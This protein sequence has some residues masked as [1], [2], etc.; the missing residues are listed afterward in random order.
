[1][2][3]DDKAR[4]NAQ[5]MPPGPVQPGERIKVIDI[6]RGF[7]LFGI[8]LVNMMFFAHP[9]YKEVLETT[10][11]SPLDR[12]ADLFISFFAEG[13]FFTLFSLLF[14]LGLAI[15]LQ[16]AEAKSINIVP[17][18]IRRL[19]V[20]LVIGLAHAFLFWFGD[21]LTYYALLGFLLLLFRSTAPRRLLRWGMVFL[22]I[23]LV[24]NAGLTG[25]MELGRTTPE[26]AA[27]IEAAFAET[28]AQYQAAYEQALTVYSGGSFAAMIPQRIADWVFATIG[29]TLGGMLFVV[30]T[31]FLVGLYIGK[32]RLLHDVQAN[33]SLWRKVFVWGA[34]LGI[35]GNLLYVMLARAGDPLEPSLM[36]L[37]GMVGYLIGAPALSLCYASGLV[38][39]AQSER[40]HARLAPLAAVGRTALSNYLLQT[41]IATTIFYGYGLG[42]YG[43]IGPALGILL[44]LLIFAVQ[45]PLSNLW[46]KRFRFGPAEWLWRTLTYGKLQPL[47]LEDER[48]VGYSG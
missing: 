17:L 37:L 4:T 23:P 24:L 46:V 35:I 32:R 2:M 27:Q 42:L 41:L 8:L 25:L 33:L 11:A 7:A 44:T 3:Q 47:R 15:Q 38:L 39:L 16:R 18:Y 1:M 28:R 26:G 45:I 30:M 5:S 48:K 19:L 36:S 22:L 14:G 43:Q 40:W 21:I 29:V 6:L 9:I 31:M 12:A 10:W 34:V 13:K 20:L